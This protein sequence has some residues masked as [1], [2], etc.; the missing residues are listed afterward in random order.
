MDTETKTFIKTIE[1]ARK[2][3]KLPD[4]HHYDLQ[5]YCEVIINLSSILHKISALEC[6]CRMD[7]IWDVDKD[8]SCGADIPEKLEQFVKT[9]LGLDVTFQGD[10]RGAPVRIVVGEGLGNSWADK[11]EYC[12]PTYDENVY[13]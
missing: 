6:S 10:P 11:A 7:L 9:Y 1:K 5:Q 4:L 13:L 3:K 8:E 2:A 12:V